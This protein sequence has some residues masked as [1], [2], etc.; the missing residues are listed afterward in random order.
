MI[1]VG[2]R[3]SQV[4]NEQ[5]RGRPRDR[6]ARRRWHGRPRFAHGGEARRLQQ[7]DAAEDLLRDVEGKLAWS[8][9][10]LAAAGT[11][12]VVGAGRGTMSRRHQIYR[13]SVYC[14]NARCSCVCGEY[15]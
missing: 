7:A 2:V 11:L 3:R 1:I 15:I 9:A 12:I 8:A 14:K 6:A 10:D 4:V 5:V 13:I